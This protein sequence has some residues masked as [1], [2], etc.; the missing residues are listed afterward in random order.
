M[1]FLRAL[2]RKWTCVYT[3]I[4]AH[5]YECTYVVKSEKGKRPL[6]MDSSSLWN[7]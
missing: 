3:H 6:G 1:N 4:G 7:T 2:V 5:V